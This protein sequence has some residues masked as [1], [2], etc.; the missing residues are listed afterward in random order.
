[1]ERTEEKSK[2]YLT[3]VDGGGGKWRRWQA[4][5]GHTATAR[6][7]MA[8]VHKSPATARSKMAS[9]HKS[10]ALCLIYMDGQ[11]LGAGGRFTRPY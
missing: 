10:P 6:S 1:M 8:S 5:G 3:G 9:V 2:I 7:K 4:R 11:F